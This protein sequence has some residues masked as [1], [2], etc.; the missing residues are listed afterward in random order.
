[1]NSV[2]TGTASQKTG[3]FSNVEK[4][5]F[6]VQPYNIAVVLTFYSPFIITFFILCLSFVFQNMKGLGFLVWLLVFSWIRNLVLQITGATEMGIN[7]TNGNK[8]KLCN[9][10]QYSKYGN[11]TFSMFFIPFSL[12]YLC[13]PMFINKSVN[14]WFFSVFLLFYFVDAFIRYSTGC[15]DQTSSIVLDSVY[16]VFSGGLAVTTMYLL[17]LQQYLFFNEMSS[18]KD[19]CTMP[20]KQTFKCRVFKNGELIGTTSG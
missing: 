20:S 18:N 8:P 14:Y 17:N 4:P 5:L 15:I 12:V 3:Q 7:G 9:M 13:V 11:D 19:V 1:M 10:I 2:N 6:I 16:G